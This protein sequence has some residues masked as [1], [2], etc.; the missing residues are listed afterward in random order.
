M[1]DTSSYSVRPWAFSRN[2]ARFQRWRWRYS[3][4][5]QKASFRSLPWII[6]IVPYPEVL[7]EPRAGSTFHPLHP[8]I[9][10]LGV[11]AALLRKCRMSWFQ[12]QDGYQHIHTRTGQYLKGSWL[13]Q[14]RTGAYCPAVS[15]CIYSYIWRR[16]W[17]AT[18]AP[19]AKGPRQA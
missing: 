9:R 16:P 13:L 10:L 7:K 19:H 1:K 5:R 6:I 8:L 3:N 15:K 14:D 18:R 2:P 11:S 4:E 17:T 12:V